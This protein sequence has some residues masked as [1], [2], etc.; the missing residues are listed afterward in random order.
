MAFISP[1]W[2]TALIPWAAVTLWLLQGRRPAVSVPYLALWHT[3]IPLPQPRRKREVLP[4]AIVMAL[5]AA[6]LAIIAGAQPAIS[7]WPSRNRWSAMLI[8]DCG[9]TMSAQ[10]SGA[11]RYV[12]AVQSLVDAIPPA[13]RSNTLELVVVPGTKPVE[14]TWD[15]V[16]KTVRSIP[17]TAR[18]T[19]RL[20]I[21]TVAAQLARG[22]GPVLAIT[23]KSLDARDRLIRIPPEGAIQDAAIVLF[24]ARAQPVPQVMVRVRNQ[25]KLRSA[26]LS[27]SCE[28]RSEHQTVA[29]PDVGQTRDY[30]FNPP[31]LGTVIAAELAARDDLPANNRAWLVRTGSAP[32]IEARTPLSAELR[33]MI[34][35]YQHSRPPSDE[36]TRLIITAD[37]TQLPAD[38][39]GVVLQLS[40]EHSITGT[41]QARPHALTAHVAW[42]Q[43]PMPVST[44]GEPPAGWSTLV[45]VDGRPILAVRPDGPHRVWVGFDAPAWP[46]T[47]DYV[48]FWTNVFDW[49]AGPEN[50][51]AAYALNQW[52]P[53]WKPT[54]PGPFEPGM[55]PGLYRR[56]DG[57][58][59]A[60]NPPDVVVP[61]P[62]RT[63]WRDRLKTLRAASNRFD[64]SKPL[65]IA[66]TACVV[67]AAATWK[68]SRPATPAPTDSRLFV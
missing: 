58:L 4:L 48:V 59:R 10:T 57:A 12:A 5:L 44:G 47:A 51:F 1:I 9:L 8:V 6:L 31:K 54:E 30:F 21:D 68:K 2:L 18:D 42:E 55:W 39:P 27:V 60:F 29:L 25:S 43:M 61:P 35:A 62:Q 46:T 53:E 22:S 13:Q 66:A 50:R 14:T 16:M 37:I 23:D 34:A 7:G 15:E 33:R 36:S 63:D 45:S 41:L 24:A 26:I 19:N 32:A 11:P 67:L 64:L 28:G 65:L 17:P 40:Q 49:V 20:M 38:A 56:S 3:Q 52:T